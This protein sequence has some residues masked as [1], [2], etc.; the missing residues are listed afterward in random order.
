MAFLLWSFAF[1]LMFPLLP[2]YASSLGARG[3]QVGLVAGV[4]AAGAA[5]L[6]F[7]LSAL[8]DRYGQRIALL[9]GWGASALGWL[10]MA[11]AATWRHLLPGAFLIT[12]PIAALP[13]LNALVLDEVPR[14]QSSRALSLVY[15][16]AP[17]G[18]LLGSALGGHLADDFGLAT[19]VRVAGAG[20]LA[21]TLCLLLLR[22]RGAAKDVA[23]PTPVAAAASAGGSRMHAKTRFV[24]L[25]LGAVITGAFTVINM[26]TNFIVPFLHE[27]GGQSMRAAGL[28]TSY[29]A[30]AQI[31]W[32][33]VFAVWP[34]SR[35][36]IRLG[37]FDLQLAPLIGIAVCLVANSVFG[38]LMP[39]GWRF[40][41]YIA[42]FLRGSQYSL[43]ALGSALLGDVVSPGAARTTRMTVLGL[44]VGVG[45]VLAPI[46][47]GWLYDDDPAAPFEVSGVTAAVAAVVL[48]VAL[49]YLA[50]GRSRSPSGPTLS[51]S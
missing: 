12:G 38:A 7:P 4:A 8:A 9:V 19:V 36:Q 21:A 23:S 26:P 27:V 13:A 40:A 41:W 44:G 22:R 31:F 29:L 24:L 11:S 3:I 42:L 5:L 17:V 25:G 39:S 37:P 10:L 6:A 15:G 30:L 45:A 1:N 50:K 48:A 18:L 35:G 2:L 43:Q 28:Y 46:M 33:L 49:W 32:S 51:Q 47:A 34:R 14:Q 20:C 16:A